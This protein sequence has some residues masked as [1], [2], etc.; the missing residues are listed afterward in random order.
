MRVMENHRLHTKIISFMPS[1]NGDE[2]IVSVSTLQRPQHAI[3]L[4]T[5]GAIPISSYEKTTDLE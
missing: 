3:Q 2:L 5:L 1:Q 4:V